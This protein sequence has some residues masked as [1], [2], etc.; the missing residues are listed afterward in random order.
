MVFVAEA[1][2]L[3]AIFCFYHFIYKIRKLP[4][5]PTPLPFFGN[6]LQLRSSPHWPD[7]FLEW[8]RK[9]GKTFTYW[10]GE[11]PIIAI[12]DVN[13]IHQVFVEDGDSFVNRYTLLNEVV[14]GGESGVMFANWD[15]AREHRRFALKF[16]KDFESQMQENILEEVKIL[17]T[18]IEKQ[19][20]Q[21]DEL[22]MF[23]LTDIAI[24][25]IL[26][27][28]LFGYKFTQ[29]NKEHEFY[30]IKEQVTK[31]KSLFSNVVLLISLTILFFN[32]IPIY[33][34]KNRCF[35]ICKA[36]DELLSDLNL[37]ISKHCERLC[38]ENITK[39]KDYVEAH[40]H[41]APQ[42][43]PHLLSEDQHEDSSA[44]SVDIQ[45]KHVVLDFWL[46]GQETTSSLLTWGLAYLIH[47]PDVQ[48]KAHEE[49]EIVVGTNRLITNS[50]KPYLPY[51]NALCME[52]E[53]CAN[54]MTENVL[55]VASADYN[56]NGYEIKKG[57]LC[58]A[59]VSALM[60]DEEVFTDPKAFKP[61]R[62]LDKKEQV[63]KCND[64]MP[65]GVGKRSCLGES[66][67]S[68]EWFLFLANLINR[69]SVS[70]F[71]KGLAQDDGSKVK[72]LPYKEM[73]ILQKWP[74]GYS[75]GIKPYKCRVIPKDQ[76]VY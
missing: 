13:L 75:S 15:H 3:I 16:F 25:S 56:L 76:R 60:E 11:L 71:I 62:F 45:L 74:A 10:F 63:A 30:R 66:L 33:L 7:K 4:P 1:A 70:E 19:R 35:N 42:K 55:R 44:I 27:Q 49:L 69:Y 18:K 65:F 31:V 43:N 73:P 9:Y 39:P 72:F 21:N 6:L 68:M 8:S 12:T 46:A 61:E 52:V 14:R 38:S 36:Y 20:E 32:V 17:L 54:V 37:N 59:Q 48:R 53:R 50:D 22:D 29:N 41:E 51:I 34:I 28:L 24:G 67:A 64:L 47:N 5:G 57:Q 2:L 23:S 26:N 58:V 40:L